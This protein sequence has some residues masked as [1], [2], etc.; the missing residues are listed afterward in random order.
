MKS[1]SAEMRSESTQPRNFRLAFQAAVKLP[2][3]YR[4]FICEGSPYAANAFIVGINA[5]TGVGRFWDFWD[6]EYGFKKA[7]LWCPAYLAE[8]GGRASPTRRHIQALLTLAGAPEC[9]ETN[10]YAQPTAHV[11]LLTDETTAAFDFLM[12]HLRPRVLLVHGKEAAEY[13]IGTYC[14]AMSRAERNRCR[15]EFVPSTLDGRS[16]L[17]LQANHL[18]LPYWNNQ[19]LEELGQQLRQA[20]VGVES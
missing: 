9:I 12:A 18:W 20:V 11:H 16:V 7:D 2:P 10:V 3:E 5:T 8:K 4:P 19:R 14:T 15:F 13:V 17:L 1:I 6:D